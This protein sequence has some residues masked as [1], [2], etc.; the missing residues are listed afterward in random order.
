[1]FI[2]SRHQKIIDDIL[3]KYPYSFFLFGS[4][5]KGLAKKFSDLDLCYFENILSSH[6]NNIEDDFEESDLPYKVDLVNWHKCS[7]EFKNSIINDLIGIKSGTYMKM[8]EQI[9]WD[10]FKYLP[11]TLGLVKTYSEY[12]LINSGFNSSMFNL[13][14]Q[15]NIKENLDKKISYILSFFKKKPLAFWL[16]PSDRPINLTFFLKKYQF[17]SNTEWVMIVDLDN[18]NEKKYSEIKIV[19]DKKTLQDFISVLLSYDNFVKD[20]YQQIKNIDNYLNEKL[21]ILYKDN[22][23][24]CIGILHI[25]NNLAGVFSLLT[26]SKYQNLGFGTAMMNHMMSIAKE[27]K[28]KYMTLSASNIHAKNIYEKLGFRTLGIFNCLERA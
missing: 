1:M 25:N 21:F 24:A 7:D 11:N 28:V 19:N 26:V 6:I 20:F 14:F 18:F 3:N 9:L 4:R 22:K 15:L 12:T 17:K 23:P 5:S 16:T 13:V 2:E 10:H 27:S 8:A